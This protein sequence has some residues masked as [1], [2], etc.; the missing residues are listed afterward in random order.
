[1]TAGFLIRVWR[2]ALIIILIVAALVSPTADI[3]NMMLFAT[4]MVGLYLISIFIAWM[5]GKKRTVSE[6]G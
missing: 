1:V 4:P 5:F 2:T 6:N 3:P